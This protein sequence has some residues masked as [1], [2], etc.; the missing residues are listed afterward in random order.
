MGWC[1]CEY[2]CVCGGGWGGGSPALVGSQSRRRT[3]ASFF[4]IQLRS[5]RAHQFYY[6]KPEPVHCGPAS[7]NNCRQAFPHELRVS[8]FS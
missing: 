8:S 2:V 6:L 1:V 7:R 4:F 5:A 3:P